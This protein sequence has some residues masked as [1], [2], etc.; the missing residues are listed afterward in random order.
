MRH[1]V[2]TQ[3]RGLIVHDRSV[4]LIRIRKN[5]LERWVLPGGGQDEGESLPQT[6]RRECREELGLSVD[7]GPLRMIREFVPKNHD[8]STSPFSVQCIDFIFRCSV[9]GAAQLNLGSQPD[10][11]ALEARWIDIDEALS[12]PLYPAVLKAHWRTLVTGDEP[13]YVGD[14]L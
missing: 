2:R 9:A 5:D 3:A 14:H 6:V 12:L 7:V 10:E 11:E 1:P 4:A 13:I 8:R